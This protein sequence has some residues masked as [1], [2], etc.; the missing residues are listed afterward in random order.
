MLNDPLK[1][2]SEDTWADLEIVMWKL[3]EV[4]KVN[5]RL[6]EA[7]FPGSK[8]T[9]LY[10][11]HLEEIIAKLKAATGDSQEV[12]IEHLQKTKLNWEQILQYYLL[13][14]RYPDEDK[15]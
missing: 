2:M 12:V 8:A 10:S 6:I 7:N 15:I 9:I 11:Q 3:R 5:K 1:P 14:G 4:A 13:H